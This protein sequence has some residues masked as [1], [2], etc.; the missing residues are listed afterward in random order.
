MRKYTE[1]RYDE[2]MLDR[3]FLFGMTGLKKRLKKTENAVG[4]IAACTFAVI[5]AL[6]VTSDFGNTAVG[7]VLSVLIGGTI[8]GGIACLLIPL[9]KRE[10]KPIA[11]KGLC[12]AERKQ[13]RVEKE[14][15]A[16]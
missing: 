13:R 12:A 4:F 7:I 2:E 15:S 11:K 6:L 14:G 1:D 8:G 16:A 10:P 9:R 3:V 5:T